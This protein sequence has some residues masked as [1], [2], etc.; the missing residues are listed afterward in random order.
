MHG[1]ATS[2][3]MLRGCPVY[4]CLV[5]T[6]TT[7][8]RAK[9]EATCGEGGNVEDTKGAKLGLLARPSSHPEDVRQSYRRPAAKGEAFVT[10]DDEPGV[11]R[12]VAP[13]SWV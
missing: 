2:D 6:P 7:L 8:H 4:R 10:L 1:R 11:P 9:N 5:L 12:I 13:V 3:S